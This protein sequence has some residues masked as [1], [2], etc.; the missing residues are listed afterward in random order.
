MPTLVDLGGHLGDLKLDLNAWIAMV[1]DVH[2]HVLELGIVEVRPMTEQFSKGSGVLDLDHARCVWLPN[3]P[4][5]LR[6]SP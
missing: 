1:R 3:A 6:A 2:A 4:A 5:H